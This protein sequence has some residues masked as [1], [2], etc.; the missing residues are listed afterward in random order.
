MWPG[1]N[2]S[3]IQSTNNN[4]N[5]NNAF[6]DD[7]ALCKHAPRSAEGFW[8]RSSE[9]GGSASTPLTGS[10]A[11]KNQKA[12]VKLREI[13]DGGVWVNLHAMQD[14]GA[15]GVSAV[16]SPS[17]QTQQ[18]PQQRQPF[19]CVLEVRLASGY[20]ARWGW[21]ERRGGSSRA[22][23]Q[24]CFELL[25]RREKRGAELKETKEELCGVNTDTSSS[26]GPPEVSF[27]GFVEPMVVGGHEKKWRH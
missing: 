8:T 22:D 13:L 17:Q 4:N 7:R 19:L 23:L 11:A 18:H 20:G 25:Q 15:G 27:R 5:N 10:E 12:A 2:C 3:T 26:G 14:A 21:R 24:R 6:Y 9:G 1:V 16:V